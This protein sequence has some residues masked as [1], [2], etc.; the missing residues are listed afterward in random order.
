MDLRALA[1]TLGRPFGPLYALAM[2]ARAQ[3]YA[4]GLMRVRRMPAPV[5]SVGNLSMG[6]TGKSPLVQYVARLL[7]AHGHKPAIISRGYGGRARGPVNVV[8]EGRGALLSAQEAGDEPRW[9]ADTLPGVPVLTGKKRHLP[10]AAA[11]RMG[12]E[13]LI[14]DDGFQHLA[15]DRDVNLALFNADRLSGNGRVFPGGELR[16]PL[17]AL[18]RATAFVLTTVGEGNR[19]GAMAFGEALTRR[20]PDR[21]VFLAAYTAAGAIRLSPG[22]DCDCLPLAV[23]QAQMATGLFAFCGIAEPGAFFQ[24][25]ASL[26]VPLKGVCALDDHHAYRAAHLPLLC[27]KARRCGA[28]ALVTTEKDLVKLAPLVHTLE[29]PLYCLR[30]QVG[31]DAAF[32]ALILAAVSRS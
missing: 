26:Q 8:S 21:P 1:F 29:L 12:A 23:A 22:G 32:D 18:K 17:S 4:H 25:L 3:A 28:Q 19:A 15:V 5:V 13:V 20:F 9:L 30:M 11:I 31:L 2:Q 27:A 7:L 16:E 24:S 14:L 6:G 10:A